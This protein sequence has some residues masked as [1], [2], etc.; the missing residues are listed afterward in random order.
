MSFKISSII[1]LVHLDF[2]SFTRALIQGILIR[3]HCEYTRPIYI[4][5]HFW[6]VTCYHTKLH[7]H[8][9]LN[10]LC[11]LNPLYMLLVMLDNTCFMPLLCYTLA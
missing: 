11:E 1:T 6:V 8:T 9:Q 10:I 4:L 7:L 2:L 3:N 5:N